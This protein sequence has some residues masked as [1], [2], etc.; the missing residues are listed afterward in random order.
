MSCG[1]VSAV[2]VHET[3]SILR[4]VVHPIWRQGAVDHS[5]PVQRLLVTVD[6]DTALGVTAPAG[7]Q[8]NSSFQVLRLREHCEENR[9]LCKRLLSDY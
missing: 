5:V 8:T 1:P 6:L 9:T 2:G 3:V 4:D 7:T